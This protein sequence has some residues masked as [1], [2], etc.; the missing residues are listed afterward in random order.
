MEFTTKTGSTAGTFGPRF[1]IKIPAGETRGSFNLLAST[2]HTGGVIVNV[3]QGGYRVTEEV[4]VVWPPAIESFVIVPQPAVK[5]E[6]AQAT[7]T[8][9]AP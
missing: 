1:N 2:A 6:T 3:V 8:L 4:P 7:I 9:R 5:G